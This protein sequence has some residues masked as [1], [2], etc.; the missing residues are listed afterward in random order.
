MMAVFVMISGL[1]FQASAEEPTPLPNQT[2]QE[3]Y[4][5]V[6]S[7]FEGKDN[8]DI[9]VIY[10][11]GKLFSF[12]YCPALYT[13]GAP[14]EV[15]QIYINRFQNTEFFSD[16]VKNEA[17]AKSLM[18]NPIC[19]LIGKSAYGYAKKF[20]MDGPDSY[21]K[22]YGWL[23][24]PNMIF[25]ISSSIAAVIKTR[26]AISDMKNVGKAKNTVTTW[27][28]LSSKELNRKNFK[29]AIASY[30]GIASSLVFS[31]I[32]NEQNEALAVLLDSALEM[33]YNTAVFF[34]NDSIATYFEKLQLAIKLSVE[35]GNLR[36]F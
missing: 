34:T 9:I 4:S 21:I 1:S 23:T 26:A 11:H 8:S 28:I 30:L 22:S 29:F 3:S 12:K 14:T 31:S 17:L 27:A 15:G 18:N 10:R 32:L 25:L 36:E 2:P 20:R 24:G 13:N 7:N 5:L 33:N 35:E 6:V 19:S 16:P